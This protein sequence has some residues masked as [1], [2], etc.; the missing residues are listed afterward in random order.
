EALLRLHPDR[1]RLQVLQWWRDSGLPLVNDAR[2]VDR[3]FQAGWTNVLQ[4]WKDSGL[5]FRYRYTSLAISEANARDRTETLQWWKE[6]GYDIENIVGS[7]DSAVRSCCLEILQWWKKSGLEIDWG[8]FYDKWAVKF[9]SEFGQI[10]MLQWWND[11][12][13]EIDWY[14][15]Q[16]HGV[17]EVKVLEWWERSGLFEQW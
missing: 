14:D 2:A 11:S 10:D 13:L 8:K 12:G 7:V 3:A 9:A 15:V 17:N 1:G 4:W 6:S 5:E 16:F